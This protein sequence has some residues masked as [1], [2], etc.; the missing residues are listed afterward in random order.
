M[1]ARI[2]ASVTLTAAGEKW[3]AAQEAQHVH[4][5]VAQDKTAQKGRYQPKALTMH[6][7]STLQRLSDLIIPADE[8]SQGALA[9]GAA[10][11]LDFLCAASDE[12]R[13][14]YTGGI[15][16]LDEYTRHHYDGKDFLAISPQQQT[17][18]LDLIAYRKNQSPELGPGIHFFTWARRMVADAYYT[19]PIGMKDLGYM[20]NGAMA[21][22]SVPAAAVEYALKRSGLG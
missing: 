21:Q 8:H 7:Y 12:M 2:G 3:L 6:E 9:A 22:F 20:G 11:F 14:I 19:S 5:A 18:V 10:D 15:A 16:W 17:E 4:Q 1:L 13:N